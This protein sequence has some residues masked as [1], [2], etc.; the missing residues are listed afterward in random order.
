[1]SALIEKSASEYV[2][3]YEAMDQTHFEFIDLI[4]QLGSARGEEFQVL[5][6]QLVAHTE[7]HFE[8]ENSWM[9]QSAFPA[10]AEHLG[11]HMRVLNDLR[12]FHTRVQR[13]SLSLAKAFISQQIPEWFKLHAATMD[14]ALAT[15]L[16][17]KNL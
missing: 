15:H 9:E 17:E 3:G 7:Q 1:M 10:K 16:K 12:Q 14:A 4:N 5:F 6:A 8:T 11:E 2:L 13:G